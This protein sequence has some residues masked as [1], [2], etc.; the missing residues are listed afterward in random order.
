MDVPQ[1]VRAYVFSVD[2]AVWMT[3]YKRHKY[4]DNRRYVYA[5]ALSGHIDHWTLCH[6]HHSSFGIPQHTWSPVRSEYSDNKTQTNYY[7]PKF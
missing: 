6:I 3:Y 4:M 2:S 1:Y 5:D 7:F